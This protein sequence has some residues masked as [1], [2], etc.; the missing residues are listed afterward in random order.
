MDGL[1]I[2]VEVVGV[3]TLDTGIAHQL[4]IGCKQGIVSLIIDIQ[5][6]AVSN[7]ILTGIST[8]SSS[9]VASSHTIVLQVQPLSL[10]PLVGT[11]AVVLGDT[12][13]VDT[14]LHVECHVHLALLTLLG[15]DQDHTVRSTV[16]IQS[17]RSSIFQNRHALDVLRVQVRDITIIRHTIQDVERC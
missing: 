12:A 2:P 7:D 11:Q 14:L 3:G 9:I 17:S 15:S 8:C 5:I 16:T 4:A 1:L 13:H 10:H 6:D